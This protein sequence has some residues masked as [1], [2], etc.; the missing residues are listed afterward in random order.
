VLASVLSRLL[1][2]VAFAG[3]GIAWSSARSSTLAVLWVISFVF[4]VVAALWYD[5]P[6]EHRPNL[7]ALWYLVPGSSKNPDDYR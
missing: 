4:L 7:S 6:P 3:F 5:I 2:G 1:A